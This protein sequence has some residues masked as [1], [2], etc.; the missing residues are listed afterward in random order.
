MKISSIDSEITSAKEFAQVGTKVFNFSSNESAFETR[1]LSFSSYSTRNRNQTGYVQARTKTAPSIP[2]VAYG[3]QHERSKQ[4]PSVF[5]STIE[6]Q[7]V[8]LEPETE[9]PPAE[10]KTSVHLVRRW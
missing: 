10:M 1:P 9:V 2:Y 8:V 4:Q 5:A 3:K 6:S 7:E